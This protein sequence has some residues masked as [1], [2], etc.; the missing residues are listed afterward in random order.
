MDTEE[1]FEEWMDNEVDSVA[2]T[3]ELG[4]LLQYTMKGIDKIIQVY[5]H[6][7]DYLIKYCGPVYDTEFVEAFDSAQDAAKIFVEVI[8]RNEMEDEEEG[9]STPAA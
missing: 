4:A 3:I 7:G 9:T 5:K 6:D 2:C 8:A 1:S